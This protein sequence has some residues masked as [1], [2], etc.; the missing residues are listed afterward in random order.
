MGTMTGQDCTLVFKTDKTLSVQ[1]GGCFHQ[2]PWIRSPWAWDGE[3]IN[4]INP[5]L[6]TKLGK[7][8][9]VSSYK[10]NLILVPQLEQAAVAKDGF[11]LA[12]CFWKSTDTR[13]VPIESDDFK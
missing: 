5:E 7:Y 13:L 4:I 9:V 11:K 6:H 1:Y 3:R 10:S 2:D 12:H 8:L